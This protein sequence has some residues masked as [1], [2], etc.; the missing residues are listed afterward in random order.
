M[1][2]LRALWILTTRY[3]C[4]TWHSALPSSTRA[5]FLICLYQTCL[6]FRFANIFS[7]NFQ[8]LCMHQNLV[9]IFGTFLYHFF[10]VSLEMVSVWSADFSFSSTFILLPSTNVLLVST[11]LRP[12]KSWQPSWLIS[13]SLLQGLTN[14]QDYLLWTWTFTQYTWALLC[15]FW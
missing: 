8:L 1:L 7:N 14:N 12:A 9:H 5:K 13:S 4:D 15:Y 2:W 3:Q 10:F 6:V 11:R